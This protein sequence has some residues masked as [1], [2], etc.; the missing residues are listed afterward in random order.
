[1]F[2]VAMPSAFSRS[3]RKNLLHRPKQHL[4]LL[5]GP[6][7]KSFTGWRKGLVRSNETPTL[8]S[9]TNEVSIPDLT[10]RVACE[11]ADFG[12]DWVAVGEQEE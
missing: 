1:M 10:G 11:S 3:L 6:V 2:D 9:G 7:E 8:C 5:S 12:E 4:S